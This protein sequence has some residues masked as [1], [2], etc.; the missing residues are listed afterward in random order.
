MESKVNYTAVGAFVIGLLMALAGA[1]WWLSSAARHADTTTYLIYATDNVTGLS[2]ASDVQYRGVKVGRVASI[3]IDPANPALIRIRV[4][5]QSGVPVRADTVA[6]LSPRGVTG[7]SVINLSGGHSPRPLLPL[8]GHRYAVIHYEPSV[9]SRLEG[10]LS[11]AAVILSK[12]AN[13]LDGLLSQRNLVAISRTLQH[14]ERTTAVLDAHRQD[15]GDTLRNLRRA[16]GQLQALAASGQQVGAQASRLLAQLQRTAQAAQGTLRR[17]DATAGQW[18][19]AGR[20]ATRLG[21]AGTQAALQL[22]RGTLPEFNR[23]GDQLQRLSSQLT[24]LSR[25]LQ[26]NPNQ[27][28]FGAPLP[29]PG[30]GEH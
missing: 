13:R 1:V 16:S 6:Q 10:G 23:L 3:E 7:L 30:P 29:P 5:I 9:F 2:P 15:L 24:D 22:Q 8:P 28:L 19:Q 20:Q 25:S 27:L 26:H 4:A 11:D 14:L 21:E 17:I 12:I 18:Q